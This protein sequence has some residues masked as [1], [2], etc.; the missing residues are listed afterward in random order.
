MKKLKYLSLLG[1]M[2]MVP[3]SPCRA[4]DHDDGETR[5]KSRNRSL[6]DLYVFRE[7]W[8]SGDAGD[9]GNLI[10]IMCTNPRSLPRQHYFFDETARYEFHVTRNVSVTDAATGQR[11]LTLRF[12]FGA[13]SA[14]TFQQAITLT[15]ID[16]AGN[17]TVATGTASTVAAPATIGPEPS[18]GELAG[19][20]LTIGGQTVTVFAG[21]RE[22]PFFF[23]VKKFF[24]FRGDLA[25]G[26]L[27]PTF[28]AGDAAGAEDFAEEYNVNAIVVRVPIAF[29]A[30]GT[31]ATVFDVWET[32][33][34]PQ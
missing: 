9:A 23:D 22:D 26:S 13:P 16:D 15:A 31:G 33:S 29:L 17:E 14:T 21:L 11:D 12:T 30:D 32:I 3:L 1:L 27:A 25:A 4:S 28:F 24:Q 5:I 18:I 34:V 2:A 8:Q 7:D 6:T 20:A 10:M 19:D